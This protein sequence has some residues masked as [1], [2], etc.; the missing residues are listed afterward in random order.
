MIKTRN[1]TRILT[2]YTDWQRYHNNFL[3]FWDSNNNYWQ[4]T[5][6]KMVNFCKMN[7][8]REKTSRVSLDW[9]DSLSYINGR[10]MYFPIIPI[11]LQRVLLVL[12]LVHTE[13]PV[14]WSDPI[15][16]GTVMVIL[17]YFSVSA[18]QLH[19]HTLILHCTA[20]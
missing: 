2:A 8:Q 14:T 16:N 15:H 18:G 9:V 6:V 10:V 12:I 11:V 19:V 4:E 1:Y 5:K 20:G 7:K 17:L 13:L 3:L